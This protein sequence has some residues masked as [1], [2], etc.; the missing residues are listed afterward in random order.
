MENFCCDFD[1]GNFLVMILVV[2][3]FLVMILS[4]ENFFG[5]VILV[6]DFFFFFC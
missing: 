4:M 6:V 1:H 3:N 2:E 5:H